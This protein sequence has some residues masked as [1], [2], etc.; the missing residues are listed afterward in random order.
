MRERLRD[1]AAGN[2]P[3]SSDHSLDIYPGPV[4]LRA[5]KANYSR[6]DPKPTGHVKDV[7][8]TNLKKSSKKNSQKKALLVEL[9][10]YPINGFELQK[11]IAF[12]FKVSVAYLVYNYQDFRMCCKIT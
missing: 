9:L 10:L 8:L 2:V 4:F 5:D 12:E 6:P 11:E 1:L 3:T 7:S